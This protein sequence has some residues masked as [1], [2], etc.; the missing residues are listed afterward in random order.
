M[1]M[2][3]LTLFLATEDHSLPIVLPISDHS[4][5]K[6]SLPYFEPS[7]ISVKGILHYE[8]AMFD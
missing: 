2:K 1:I 6:H 4:F 8:L 3:H 7:T 5:V